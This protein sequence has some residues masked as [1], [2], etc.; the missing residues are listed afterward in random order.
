GN[1]AS[2]TT[3]ITVSIVQPVAENVNWT[4]AVGVTVS[5]NSI[6]SNGGSGW[7]TSGAVSTRNL[8]SGDG[9]VELTAVNTNTAAMCGFGY[10]DSSQD[11]SDIDFGI[12]LDLGSLQV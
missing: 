6:T 3:P 8:A 5:G 1:H 4:N 2:A 12:Y 11:Y 9:Y 10:G 7:G